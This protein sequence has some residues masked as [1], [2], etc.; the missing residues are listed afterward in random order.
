MSKHNKPFIFKH[1][2]VEHCRSSMKV[3]IDAVV[4]GAWA[5]LPENS[6]RV[7]DVGCGC[8]VISM[9]IAQRYPQV[10]VMGIDIHD[11]S[12]LECKN[13]FSSCQWSDRLLAIKEDFLNIKGMFD[14]VISNP[15]YF[16]DGLK[17]I[18]SARLIARHQGNLNPTVLIKNGCNVLTPNGKIGIVVPY[19]A[20]N[21]L[22]HNIE[23]VTVRPSRI[24]L[25]AG[26]PGLDW[27]RCFIE[28][29]K[30][31]IEWN[32]NINN[33]YIFSIVEKMY[34]EEAN[35]YYS[36]IYRSLCKDFYLKF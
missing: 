17:N 4:L 13:N 33:D 16:E 14:Y 30:S 19:H 12:I 35:G 36:D 9:M 25:M 29:E 26:K 11:E 21:Q 34:V 27:K 23:G 32:F 31:D 10:S 20:L 15:P 22:L 1:F 7:I 24:L 5:N 3:G 8:G 6:K 28:L 2:Q 18:N